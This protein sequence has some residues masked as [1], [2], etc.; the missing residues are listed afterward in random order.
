MLIRVIFYLLLVFSFTSIHANALLTTAKVTIRVVDEIGKPIEG[1]KVGI[2]F[3]YNSGGR[4]LDRNVNGLTSSEGHFEGNS[5]CNGNIGF[6]VTKDGYYATLGSYDF[7][8]LGTFGWEPHNPELTVILR[9][10]GN[11]I[12]MYAR[13][14]DR[15]EIEI[16]E[17]NKDIGFDLIKFDWVAPYGIGTHSDFIF[18]LRKNI[19]STNEYS[20]E[21]DLKFSKETDGLLSI[22][23]ELQYG[24]NFKLPR[25]APLIGYQNKFMFYAKKSQNIPSRSRRENQNYIFRVRSSVDEDGN[26]QGMY[27]KILGDFDIGTKLEGTA[28]IKFK[29]YLNPDG[30][31]NLEYDPRKNLF[32]KLP[33]RER[34]SK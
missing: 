20:F 30:T 28:Y 2:G 24:S 5:S 22:E 12:P 31:R 17:T 3:N 32:V 26:V 13:N 9:E 8:K 1:A 7:E 19:S 10:I 16:P 34:V 29:Y 14:T 33:H 25:E 21:L 23:E 18:Q 11:R 27:G 15:S 4:T 6:T